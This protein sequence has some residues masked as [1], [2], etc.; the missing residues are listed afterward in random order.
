MTNELDTRKQQLVNPADLP[1]YDSTDDDG[2]SDTPLEVG[3]YIKIDHDH[4]GLFAVKNTITGEQPSV[5]DLSVVVL[6]DYYYARVRFESGNAVCKSRDGIV[7]VNPITGEECGHCRKCEWNKRDG[8]D[9]CQ[10]KPIL[11]GNEIGHGLGLVIVTFSASALRPLRNLKSLLQI[12]AQKAG[13]QAKK[14]PLYFFP[15]HITTER[16]EQKGYK[17]YYLPKF[18]LG[19]ILAKEEIAEYRNQRKKFLDLV[20]EE[21]WLDMEQA[22]E[23]AQAEDEDLP[24]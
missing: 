13:Y 18:D 9:R 19:D 1:E 5:K 4:E 2:Y 16:V 6:G 14:L 11:I 17:P 3:T 23:A 12:E 8:D 21:D 7:G 22:K 15:L 24:F 10:S 20:K